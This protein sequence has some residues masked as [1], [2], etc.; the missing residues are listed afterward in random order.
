MM[1]K[2]SRVNQIVNLIWF[3]SFSV[4][5]SSPFD[6]SGLVILRFSDKHRH[7]EST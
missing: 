1:L 2:R 3:V 4:L 6:I 7:V 5:L